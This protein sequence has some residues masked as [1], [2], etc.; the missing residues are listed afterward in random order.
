MNAVTIYKVIINKVIVRI[1]LLNDLILI[2]WARR[3][4]QHVGDK[5]NPSNNNDI[6]LWKNLSHFPTTAHSIYQKKVMRCVPRG[7]SGI[8]GVCYKQ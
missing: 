8:T 7:K 1:R 3:E 4:Q 2:I 6:D 5:S